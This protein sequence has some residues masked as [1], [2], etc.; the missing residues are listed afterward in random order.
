MD[1]THYITCVTPFQA[2][3]LFQQYIVDVFVA[4]DQAKLDWIHMN[5]ASIQ[6][7]LYNG[8]V[9]AIVILLGGEFAQIAPVVRRAN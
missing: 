7:D 6:A 3:R 9:D 1:Y 8:L 2:G 4:V 5:Q